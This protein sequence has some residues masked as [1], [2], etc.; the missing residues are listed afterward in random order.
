MIR[1]LACLLFLMPVLCSATPSTSEHEQ[2]TGLYIQVNIDNQSRIVLQIESGDLQA[3]GSAF[4]PRGFAEVTLDATYKGQLI[5]NWGKAEISLECNQASV[6]VY[7][8][9]QQQY[10]ERAASLIKTDFCMRTIT[11]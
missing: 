7:Q 4:G 2:G 9:V 6:I 3:M 11:H 5:P 10:V 1:V 8:L